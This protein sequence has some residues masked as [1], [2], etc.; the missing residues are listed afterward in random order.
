MPTFSELISDLIFH[1]LHGRDPWRHLAVR[2]LRGAEVSP[3][4]IS[5]LQCQMV[6]NL[7]NAEGVLGVLRAHGNHATV[8]P[9]EEVV[10]RLILIKAHGCR[11]MLLHIG[12]VLIVLNR[13]ITL[14]DQE[15]CSADEEATC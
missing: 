8:L 6:L 1:F 7:A 12:H 5:C 10:S 4:K 2:L 14:H 9:Q 3:G 15:V 11:A 13:G